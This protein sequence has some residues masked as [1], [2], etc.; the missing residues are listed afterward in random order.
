M[1]KPTG[2]K[3]MS[4][5]SK[6]K[7]DQRPI[8]CGTDFS[9]VA[10]EAVDLAAEMA[11]RLDVKLLLLHVQEFG[12]LSVHDPGLFEEVVLNSRRELHRHAERL[13][14]LGTVVDARVLSGSI[15]DELLDAATRAEA[16]LMVLGAVGHGI[17]R[18]LLIGSVA[19]RV[20]ETS[21]IPTI[22]VTPGSR[23]GTWLRGQHPLKVLV[24]YDFSAPSDAALRWLNEMQKLGP[25][26]TSVAHLDWPPEEARRLGYNGPLPLTENPEEIQNLLERD[27]AERVAMLLLP[28]KVTIKVEPEWG[29]T[30]GYLFEMAHR[31][32]VDLV[33]VGTH[34]R[35]GWGRLRFGSVSRPVLHHSTV[36]VAVVP[37][38]RETTRPALPKLRRVLVATDFSDLGNKAV[39]YGCAV[40]RKGGT[41]KLIHIIEPA[42]KGA[43]TKPRPAKS[44]P[45]FASRLRALLPEDAAERF[46]LEL[47]VIES[48]EVAEAIAQETERFRADAIC[49]GSHGRTELAK[50]FAGSVAQGV[51]AKTTRPILIVRAE[52]K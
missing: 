8:V 16:R 7:K 9:P 12:G 18:R 4:G 45:K 50:T 20:A 23:L 13:R 11:R 33:V 15:L 42:E 10:I 5:N 27:L 3:I 39:P 48:G 36:T 51:L 32:R 30:E 2:E 34:R 38:A 14:K 46:D 37:R 22:V 52:G 28:E 17:A 49:L 40:L 26:E 25:C 43:K 24:G 6:P 47:E 41:L 31:D 29:H 21:A 19:E 1:Q 44:N 35:H